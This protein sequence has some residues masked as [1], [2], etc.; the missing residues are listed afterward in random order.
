MT[1]AFN[2]RPQLW[3]AFGI[4]I[5]RTTCNAQ[6]A[7]RPGDVVLG[8]NQCPAYLLNR[9]FLRRP[10]TRIASV[11]C[12]VRLESRHRRQ[13]FYVRLPAGRAGALTVVRRDLIIKLAAKY[14]LPAIYD[15]RLFAAS[16]LIS[17]GPD[18]I[19]QFRRAASYVDRSASECRRRCSRAPT[20]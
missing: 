2:S 8:L 16:G 6:K 1:V 18:V 5:D 3:V 10:K 17:Y 12:R 7:S 13:N 4:F 19:D 14:K 9:K 20:R 11:P 15:R